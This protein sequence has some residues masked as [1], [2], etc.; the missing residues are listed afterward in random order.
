MSVA[1]TYFT[2]NLDLFLDVFLLGIFFITDSVSLL[3]IS[4]FIFF[5]FIHDSVLENMCF[6]KLAFFFI[7]V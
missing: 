4:L 3:V 5:I 6:R 7:V 1:S 2:A